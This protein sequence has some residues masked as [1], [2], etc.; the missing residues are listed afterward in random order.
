MT[1]YTYQLPF[2][3]GRLKPIEIFDDQQ[4][5]LGSFQRYYRNTI[6]KI[7]D[8]VMGYDF[9]LN[10]R[11]LDADHQLICELM[12]EMHFKSWLRTTWKGYSRNLGD[13]TLHDKSKI[14]THPRM[15]V[16][17]SVGDTYLIQKD[18]ADRRVWFKDKDG[19]TL[20]E[21][22]YDKIMPP[23]TINI[24]LHSSELQVY[25]AAVLY[26]ILSMKY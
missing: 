22:T 12:E 17:T 21:V 3:R 7:I 16:H 18:F 10:V 26:Y 19:R 1:S 5:K 8:R 14:K 15:E 20:A 23:Q 9:A 4:Q 11:S 6:Q 13:F 24:H 2:Y 25:E